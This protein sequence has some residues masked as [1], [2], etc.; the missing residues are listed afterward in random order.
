MRL[1][2]CATCRRHVR[3]GEHVCPF[4]GVKLALLAASLLVT[5]TPALAHADAGAEAPV[6]DAGADDDAG[7]AGNLFDRDDLGRTVHPL[8]GMP[9][10]SSSCFCDLASPSPSTDAGAASAAALASAL[11]L[12]RRRKRAP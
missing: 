2:P 10:T 6:S 5:S 12:A 4:C 8:Y 3:I 11:L 7:D 9:H 1:L